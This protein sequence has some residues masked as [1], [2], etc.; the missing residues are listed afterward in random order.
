MLPSSGMRSQVEGAGFWGK[1]LYS[2][3]FIHDPLKA[4]FSLKRFVRS[5]VS[6]QRAQLLC[7]DGSP[8]ESRI[9]LLCKCRERGQRCTPASFKVGSL[10][11]KSM[12]FFVIDGSFKLAGPFIFHL[13][14]V[15]KYYSG[16]QGERRS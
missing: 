4:L 13:D 11:L 2:L 10:L 14:F 8:D 5:L 3:L 7:Q 6:F 12:P 15:L 16:A 1:G 9:T